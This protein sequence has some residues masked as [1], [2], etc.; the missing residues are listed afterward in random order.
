MIGQKWRVVTRITLA[1]SDIQIDE[2]RMRNLER[3]ERA[4]KN[5]F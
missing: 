4:L 2:H 1:V 5:D 3:S